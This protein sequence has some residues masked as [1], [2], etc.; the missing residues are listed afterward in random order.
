MAQRPLWHVLQ[1]S[2]GQDLHPRDHALLL[3]SGEASEVVGMWDPWCTPLLVLLAFAVTPGQENGAA[4]GMGIILL[5]VVT[6]LCCCILAS[7]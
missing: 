5:M 7:A 6:M 4:S 3:R 1:V 2:A